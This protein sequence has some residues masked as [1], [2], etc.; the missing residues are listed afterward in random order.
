ML[1]GEE[2][3]GGR[4]PPDPEARQLPDRLGFAL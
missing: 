1:I 2:K 3:A 4:R